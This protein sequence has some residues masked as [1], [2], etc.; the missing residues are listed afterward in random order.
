M[1]NVI[2]RLMFFAAALAVPGRA[3]A[4]DWQPTRFDPTNIQA[5]GYRLVFDAEFNSLADI[6]FSIA[7]NGKPGAKFYARMFDKWGGTAMS[8]RPRAFTLSNGVLTVAGGQIASIAP[9]P[10][11]PQGYVGTTFRGGAYF[12]ARL[13][14]DRSK[15]RPDLNKPI[16]N[17]TNWWPS[18]Y[19]VPVEY[20]NETDQWPGM[21]RGYVHFVENDW[22]EAWSGD[23]YGA[24]LHDWYGPLH[25]YGRPRAL[26]YCNIANDGV[27]D[28]HPD[29]PATDGVAK[30]Q[31]RVYMGTAD[32]TGFHVIGALWISALHAKD[33]VGYVQYYFDNEPTPV[34]KSWNRSTND[35]IAPPV[36]G[37]IFSELDKDRSVIFI[38]APRNVPLQVAWIRVWQL[39]NDES[40]PPIA[41]DYGTTGPRGGRHE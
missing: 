37:S 12:E 10:E 6:D 33:G 8:A 40:N 14:W 13:A 4:G 32:P 26:D 22:F 20:F 25:C 7:A 15:V 30:D 18:F 31:N 19:S 39:A 11:T 16:N 17:F 1:M 29:N 23:Y 21:P 35:N 36:A 5:Y 34:W 28:A 38:G 24:T 27:S 2:L 9:A 3:I 41:P